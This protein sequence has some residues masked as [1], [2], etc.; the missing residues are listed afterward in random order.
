[1]TKRQQLIII[2]I[3]AVLSIAASYVLA[4]QVERRDVFLRNA[5]ASVIL[6]S[7]VVVFYVLYKAVLKK[8]NKDAFPAIE[9]PKLFEIESA[10]VNGEI[11]FYFTLPAS[12]NSKLL[13]LNED[14]SENTVIVDE[15]FK[16]G[17][18]IVRFNVNQLQN[19]V[20]FYCLQTDIRKS[21]KRMKVQHDKLA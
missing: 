11:E 21:M 1:M 13:I 10:V 15:M 16:T 17:G 6:I 12:M 19:G 14:L 18:H 20:Y 8:L 9:Y 5:C 4:T 3:C 7:A 2:S